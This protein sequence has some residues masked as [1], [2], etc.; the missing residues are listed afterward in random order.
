MKRNLEKSEAKV[1][2]QQAIINY[3][4]NEI[5]EFEK[6]VKNQTEQLK[7][8]AESAV[9]A[10]NQIDQVNKQ[11]TELKNKVNELE[12]LI[13]Q[14]FSSRNF[15]NYSFVKSSE[16]KKPGPGGKLVEVDDEESGK[17]QR[18]RQSSIK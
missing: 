3:Q 14:R 2:E 12:K 6:K 9:K 7:K 1:A 10:R 16:T 11:N 18:K 13:K 15:E 4:R 5:V 17:G 8:M